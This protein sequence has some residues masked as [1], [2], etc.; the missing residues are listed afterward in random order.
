[1]NLTLQGP[2]RDGRQSG[3]IDFVWTMAFVGVLGI[4]LP[5]SLAHGWGTPFRSSNHAL[6]FLLCVFSAGRLGAL[7]G[8]EKRQY[9]TITFYLFVYVWF[10]LAAVVQVSA[11]YFH[12]PEYFLGRGFSQSTRITATAVIWIGILAYEV[13]LRG[14]SRRASSQPRTYR[15]IDPFRVHLLAAAGLLSSASALLFSG[16]VAVLFTSRE[17]FYATFGTRAESGY[18]A[19]A[20]DVALRIPIF[21]AAVLI[22]YLY[23]RPGGLSWRRATV[24]RRALAVATVSA[25]LVVNNLASSTRAIAGALA[26]SLLFAWLRP[27]QKVVRRLAFVAILL[28]VLY[29]YPLASSFRRA[30]PVR[31]QRSETERTLRHSLLYG[32]GFGMFGQVHTG[33]EFVDQ[34]GHTFGRQLLGSALFLVPR[35]IW[36]DKPVDTGDMMHDALGYPTRLNQSSPLWTELYVDGGF[37]FL[38]LGFAALGLVTGHL[39]RRFDDGDP[40]SLAAVLV[41]VLAG[42]QLYILRG[43]LLAVT[44]RLTVLLLLV[45]LTT[46]RVRAPKGAQSPSR[47]LV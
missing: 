15:K 9:L 37:P 12:F 20:A 31:A 16:S 30:E 6:V 25:A 42:Y 21:V 13:G 32:H 40:F 24:G 43:S 44:P 47:V 7:L 8:S 4:I 46:T 5:L 14:R 36:T 45:V 39:Q 17:E 23:R 10:G 38:V 28:G 19:L 35:T 2:A 26:F 22:V 41:P 1:M 3:F 33:V 29:V 18:A 27:D 11:D 34:D